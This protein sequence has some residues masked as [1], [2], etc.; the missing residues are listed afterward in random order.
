VT[1]SHLGRRTTEFVDAFAVARR[2][3]RRAALLQW[4]GDAALDEYEVRVGSEPVPTVVTLFPD[5]VLVEPLT[6]A[7]TSAPLSLVDGVVRDGH[8]I[9]LDLRVLDPVV[10]GPL[11]RRTDEF[12]LG[13]ERARHALAQRTQDAYA[14]LSSALTGFSAPDGWAVGAAEAGPWWG[15]LRAAVAAGRPEEVEQLA[16]LAGPDLRLGVKVSA[17]GSAMPFV[18]APVGDL[19]AVE[20]TEEGEARATFVFRTRDVGHLNAALLLTSFRREAI[21][22]PDDALGRWALAA[23]TL[24]MVRWARTALVARVIHDDSWSATIG[25]VLG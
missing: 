25:S 14:E 1:L 12:V 20:G 18:L 11:G 17:S 5:G 15:A 24:E 7:P 22:L 2:R 21:A 23:R 9:T 3:A 13:L 6:G 19:V 8:R 16:G 4:T 10:I